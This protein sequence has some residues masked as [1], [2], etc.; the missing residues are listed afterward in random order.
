[1]DW[2]ELSRDESQRMY[3]C[4]CDADEINC[5]DQYI[6]LRDDLLLL[7][8]NALDRIGI[9]E[10]EISQKNNMSKIRGNNTKP[11]ELVRKY[12][13]SKGFRKNDR[14]LPGTPDIVLPKYRTV[15]FVNKSFLA[16]GG[17]KRMEAVKKI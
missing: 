16:H 3:D 13:F 4:Y 15:I 1:M 6:S 7:F 2:K 11:E 10:E 12:L 5:P 17:Y 8:S 14:R 9:T